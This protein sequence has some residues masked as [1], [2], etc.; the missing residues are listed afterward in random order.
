MSWW[1]I[2]EKENA[3]VSFGKV[4]NGIDSVWEGLSCAISKDTVDQLESGT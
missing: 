2:V 4:V 3:L 1:F